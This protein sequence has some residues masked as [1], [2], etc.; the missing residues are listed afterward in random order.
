M[1]RTNDDDDALNDDDDALKECVRDVTKLLVRFLERSVRER[2]GKGEAADRWPAGAESGAWGLLREFAESD[3]RRR[4]QSAAESR[5]RRLKTND[6]VGLR[7]GLGRDDAR[8]LEVNGLEPI[9]L[10]RREFLFLLALAHDPQPLLWTLEG[11]ERAGYVSMERLLKRVAAMQSRWLKAAG[12][13]GTDA[14]W[15]FPSDEDM[16]C[17]ARIIRVKLDKA[18]ANPKLLE[19]GVARRGYRLSTAHRQI[20][21]ELSGVGSEGLLG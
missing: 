5:A 15:M 4:E 11:F 6:L 17:L 3:A 19:T 7:G 14:F 21:I 10:S 2:G 12:L 16:R 1:R 8:T 20:S 9:P 13:E 18:G